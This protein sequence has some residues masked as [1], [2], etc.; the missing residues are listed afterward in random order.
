MNAIVRPRRFGVWIVIAIALAAGG[1]YWV[2]SK[3]KEPTITME[4]A[5]VKRGPLL[6]TI[7]STGSL[8]PQQEVTVG[9]QVSGTI[10]KVLV[11]F[12]SQVKKGDLLAVVDPQTLQAQLVTAKA[13]MLKSQAQYDEA[14]R[15]LE[16]GKPLREQGYL[17]SHDLRTLELAV[18]T[19]KAQLDSS[20]ADYNRQNVQLTYAEVRSPIDGVVESRTV[21]PGNTVQAAMTAPTLFVIASDLS[22]MKILATVDETQIASIKAGM[23]A[24][25]TVSGIANRTFNATVTQVRLKSTTTNNVVTYTV[26]LDA[27]NPDKV[28][29]P[30]MTATI[31]FIISNIEDALLVTNAALRVRVPDE[32]RDEVSKTPQGAEG[33]PPGAMPPGDL[34]S[35]MPPGGPPTGRAPDGM[36]PAGGTR[37]TFGNGANDAR[38]GER[39]GNRNVLWVMNAAGKAQRVPVQVIASDLTNT[40]VKPLREGMLKEG[41]MV[42]TRVNDP[43]AEASASSRGNGQNRNNQFPGMGGPP[44][45]GFG[46]R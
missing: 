43:N 29:F 24:R 33:A 22:T 6:E 2:K 38:I 25:F 36:P 13:T 12:N 30:G 1:A 21:D 31:D 42:V 32:L 15:Q 3:K 14:M 17:S 5:P 40:A 19:A 18:E 39:R 9:T 28:L 20:K 44:G 7:A 10:T 35:G 37:P 8:S 16:E 45:G 26:V 27:E 46:G 4:T 11:D 34:P 23:K 41:D